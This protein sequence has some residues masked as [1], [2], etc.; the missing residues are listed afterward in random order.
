MTTEP[1]INQL[2]QLGA[3]SVRG[4][5]L[6]FCHSPSLLF[7]Q[8]DMDR[9]KYKKDDFFDQLS[10]EALDRNERKPLSEQRRIDMETFGGLGAVRH[11]WGGRGRGRGGYQ[12]GTGGHHQ[13]GGGGGYQGGSGGYQGGG[14][15][16]QGGR[17]GGSGGYHSGGRGGY[18]GGRVSVCVGF[19]W[20]GRTGVIV[21]AV[22][23]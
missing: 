13:G 16:Y 14:G 21:V 20:L 12:S 22:M 11:N 15:G 8:V 10:C 18:Q 7:P 9:D 3:K 23:V 17:G 5:W 19:S 2:M 6:I 1:S 4:C